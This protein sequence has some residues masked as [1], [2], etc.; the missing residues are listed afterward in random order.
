MRFYPLEKLINLHDNYRRVFKIDSHA[1][2]LLQREGELHLIEATCPHREQGLQAAALHGDEI[3]C[4][5]HGYRFSLRDG[6]VLHA[7]EESCRG[8][9]VYPLEY[10]GNEVGVLLGERG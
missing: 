2:L 10:E 4:P 1:M 8:L 6:R 9:K 7:A 5:R 3:E